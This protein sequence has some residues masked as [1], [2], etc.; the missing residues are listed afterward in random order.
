M[1]AVQSDRGEAWGG[2]AEGAA[3]GLKR[4]AALEHFIEQRNG[5]GLV[6]RRAVFA[7][8][9]TT[10][11]L[12][13]LLATCYLPGAPS[14]RRSLQTCDCCARPTPS[15]APPYAENSRSEASAKF[16]LQHAHQR[17]I[18]LRAASSLDQP[19]INGGCVLLVAGHTGVG[20]HTHR[21]RCVVDLPSRAARH[22]RRGGRATALRATRQAARAAMV[23][24]TP[25]AP[26]EKRRRLNPNLPPEARADGR[27]SQEEATSPLCC[28]CIITICCTCCICCC[29]GERPRAAARHAARHLLLAALGGGASG[30]PWQRLSRRP[31]CDALVG[32]PPQ[33]ARHRGEHRLTHSAQG[34]A[35]DAGA[36]QR[37]RRLP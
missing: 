37:C 8:L 21:H 10:Y 7:S 19:G 35:P 11:Y 17:Q 33:R 26:V 5:R 13:L 18:K 32:R 12:H 29:R 30:V 16:A 28:C 6:D 23:R 4:E 27:P 31:R 2:A 22:Q 15:W 24:V 36:R 9:L 1:V 14:S 3:L 20:F 34:P 25:P